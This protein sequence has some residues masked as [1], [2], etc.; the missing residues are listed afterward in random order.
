MLDGLTGKPKGN[1]PIFGDS[2]RRGTFLAISTVFVEGWSIWHQESVAR[3]G[4]AGDALGSGCLC[5]HPDAGS[6]CGGVCVATTH[7]SR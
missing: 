3:P 6:A 2:G 4:D 7:V 1:E 5:L